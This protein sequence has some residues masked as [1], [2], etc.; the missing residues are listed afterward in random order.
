MAD[1]SQPDNIKKSLT[2]LG[3][4]YGEERIN[5]VAI[6]PHSENVTGRTRSLDDAEIKSFLT[7]NYNK[8]NLYYSVNTAREGAP[9]GKLKKETY[10][11]DPCGMDR[12]RSETLPRRRRF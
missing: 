12:C 1:N 11:H 9:D 5:L 10:R 2:F 3:A 8:R 4:L 7:Q 6:D